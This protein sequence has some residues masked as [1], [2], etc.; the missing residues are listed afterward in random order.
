[1]PSSDNSVGNGK[2]QSFDEDNLRKWCR[3]E[4]NRV[5]ARNSRE[6]KKN[7]VEM[8]QLQIEHLK[9]EKSLLTANVAAA[10][11]AEILM[12]LSSENATNTPEACAS[13]VKE[14]EATS[15]YNGQ[16]KS[17]S[18][19]SETTSDHDDSHESAESD[20]IDTEAECDKIDHETLVNMTGGDLEAIRRERNRL[21]ARTARRR[22]KKMLEEMEKVIQQLESEVSE[23]RQKEQLLCKS[24]LNRDPL[25]TTAETPTPEIS[26]ADNKM[27]TLASITLA[28]IADPVQQ[29]EASNT[30]QDSE[31]V[32]TPII[33]KRKRREN[34]AVTGYRVLN[35]MGYG[36]KQVVSMQPPQPPASSFN[37]NS[38]LPQIVDCDKQRQHMLMSLEHMNSSYASQYYL[39]PDPSMHGPSQNSPSEVYV[40]DSTGDG[41]G[42][43]DESID[44]LYVE[45]YNILARGLA[46]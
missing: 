14:V 40:T 27:E 5:H 38:R 24:K 20:E 15:S 32:D 29:V 26:P 33:K 34:T 25:A 22:K 7:Q 43:T 28:S 23:L 36:S 18:G 4:K 16:E 12:T 21:H 9:K 13:D 45:A 39:C 41:S 37:F 1:M 10:S 46:I 35:R 30:K 11:V 31:L 2:V 17:V 44:D 19:S 42:A 3:R 8:M 6:R